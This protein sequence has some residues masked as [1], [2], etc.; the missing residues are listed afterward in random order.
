MF[1][2]TWVVPVDH[3]A[4]AGHF[5][6]SPILPGVLMLDRVVHAA[7]RLANQPE[8]GAHLGNAKF[9]QPVRP[10]QTLVFRLAGSERGGMRFEV[11]AGETLVASGSLDW[12]GPGR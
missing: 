1:E 10:G 7:A 5:P 4:F 8:A 11:L 6:A 12:A 2:H 3:P 9:L